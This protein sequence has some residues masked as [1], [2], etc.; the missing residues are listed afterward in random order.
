MRV[1]QCA[2]A[3]SDLRLGQR[4]AMTPGVTLGVVDEARTFRDGVLGVRDSV[5]GFEVVGS[6]GRAGRV[7]WGSY[8]P[9]ESYLVVTTGR[10]RRRHRVLPAGAVVR[11]GDSEVYV[12][13]SRS[14]IERLPLL[15]HPQAPV[16][17]EAFQQMLNA[18]ERAASAPQT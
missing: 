5:K 10:L 8:A 15:P 12:G 1:R 4:F 11:V 14:D 18:L 16:G 2:A 9:E 3:E 6:D 7:S 17:E 13:M